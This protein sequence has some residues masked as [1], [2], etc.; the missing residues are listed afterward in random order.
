MKTV[1]YSLLMLSLG[2]TSA[3]AHE[4]SEGNS[5]EGENIRIVREIR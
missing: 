5:T 1:F 4:V 2:L 3:F